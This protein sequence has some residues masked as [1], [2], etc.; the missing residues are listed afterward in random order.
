[1]PE[2]AL[3]QMVRCGKDIQVSYGWFCLIRCRQSNKDN[4]RTFSHVIF[5]F[6]LFFKLNFVVVNEIHIAY[7]S[8]SIDTFLIQ[9]F[10]V[11][12]LT[13]KGKWE[14]VQQEVLINLKELIGKG[15]MRN[16]YRAVVSHFPKQ[17]NLL[18]RNGW[19]AKKYKS[20]V[21]DNMCE[22]WCK[23]VSV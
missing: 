2:S 3:A 11:E 7:L 21:L 10:T 23:K 19:V 5:Q 14:T 6:S 1:M 15:G 13:F 4:K 12:M 18:A 17:C 8:L 9:A 16:C 20:K 22:L